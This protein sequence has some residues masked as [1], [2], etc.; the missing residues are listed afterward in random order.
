MSGTMAC[1]CLGRNE[2]WEHSGGMNNCIGGQVLCIQLYR[3]PIIQII[4]ID[5]EVMIQDDVFL[6]K[7]FKRKWRRGIAYHGCVMD[8]L[9]RPQ[10]VAFTLR[11]LMEVP[12]YQGRIIIQY[13]EDEKKMIR[14][15]ARHGVKNYEIVRPYK[16]GV[17][18]GYIN[19]NISSD[20]FNAKFLQELFTRHYGKDFSTDNAI[21]I[22][23]FVVI[24]TGGNEIIAFHFYDDRGFY[25][26][27]VRKRM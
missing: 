16:H 1:N 19:I 15:F 11:R 24:D 18:P 9:S 25:E 17:T 20:S 5:M 14:I 12:F 3:T 10:K 23:L 2:T 26:Y 22:V 6:K 7:I 21:D 13:W 4:A 27:F 8:Y